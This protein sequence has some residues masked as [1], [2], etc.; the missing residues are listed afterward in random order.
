MTVDSLCFRGICREN[1]D[2]VLNEKLIYT[3]TIRLF[4]LEFY[5]VTVAGA[6]PSSTITRYKS[7]ANNPIVSVETSSKSYSK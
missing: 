3:K 2:K 4:A 6:A 5:R 1:L 7:R